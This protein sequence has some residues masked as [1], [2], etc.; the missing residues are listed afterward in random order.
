ML[1]EITDRDKYHIFHFYVKLKEQSKQT[2]KNRKKLR[3]R[4]QN[5]GCQ[6]VGGRLGSQIKRVYGLRRT[7]WQLENSHGT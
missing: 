6:I 1:S 7:N 4:E 3:Y 5:D 2:N